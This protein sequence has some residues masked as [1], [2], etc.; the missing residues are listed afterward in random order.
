MSFMCFSNYCFEIVVHY[1]QC[2]VDIVA[3]NNMI[4]CL[5]LNIFL[6]VDIFAFNVL[7]QIV[8]NKYFIYTNYCNF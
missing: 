6:F 2:S 1:R 5:V 3:I 8:Y 7:M 4:S